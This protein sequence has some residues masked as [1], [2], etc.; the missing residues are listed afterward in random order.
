MK[1]KNT[2]SYFDEAVPP[3]EVNVDN[4]EQVKRSSGEER[5]A[6][7][8]AELRSSSTHYGV[9]MGLVLV[10]P[11]CAIAYSGLFIFCS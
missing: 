10:V 5:N 9:E 1:Q 8:S 3:K 7:P 11:S 6:V 2:R 4:P